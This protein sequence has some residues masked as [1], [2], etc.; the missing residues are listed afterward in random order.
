MLKRFR[1]AKES[2][3]LG[4]K[5]LLGPIVVREILGGSE[6]K[7]QTKDAQTKEEVNQE[8]QKS[9]NE[10]GSTYHH[11]FEPN[12]RYFTICVYALAVLAIGVVII[13]SII[14]LPHIFSALDR[15]LFII[16][17][18]IVAFFIAFI[19]NPI[20]K[21]LAERFFHRV[22]R[23]KS[24]KVCLALGILTAYVLVIGLITAFCIYVIPQISDSIAKLT[25]QSSELYKEIFKFLNSLESRTT[26]DLSWI[27]EKIEETSPQLITLGTDIVTNLLPKLLNF[28][29]SILKLVINI[30]LS[31]AISIYMLYDKRNLS[32]NTTRVIYS[33]IP[34]KKATAILQLTKE[35]GKIFTNFIVGKTID[36][37]I[38]GMLCF[39]IMSIL[40]LD[41]AILISVIVGVTN[42][43][44]YFGPFIGAVPGILLYLCID[45][46]QAIVFSIM[47][48]G[49]QQFDGWILGPKI[50]GDSTGLTPLWVIFGIT[51]GGAYGGVFG[52]FLGVPI[53]AVV[54]Y[55]AN[56]FITSRLKK[57]NI[58]IE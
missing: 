5:D 6:K 50:L 40:R 15:F 20:V 57:K 27:E 42:M 2:E 52:M 4:E 7:G 41:Y 21:S 45:P 48:L 3:E 49:L 17:P 29:L 13:Q 54:A 8:G 12:N 18:F 23:I 10:E 28:S 9:R 1:R 32:K 37:T 11:Y 24:A 35:C 34:R 44:P 14:S 16:Q 43:I 30:L 38:I 26:L 47:V 53:V 39:V 33:L 36:S 31:I 22:C 46:V 51:V 19:V 58:V 55:L 25:S 56:L